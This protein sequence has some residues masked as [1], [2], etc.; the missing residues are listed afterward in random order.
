[1]ENGRSKY[2]I[3]K[4][5]IIEKGWQGNIANSNKYMLNLF[6][7]NRK[8]CKKEYK[9]FKMELANNSQCD[10]A[11]SS[12][13]IQREAVEEAC[14]VYG[15]EPILE[16]VAIN[17]RLIYYRVV[18]TNI[19]LV[20]DDHYHIHLIDYKIGNDIIPYILVKINIMLEQGLNYRDFYRCKTEKMKNI[21][22]TVG[23]FI[24]DKLDKHFKG[25]QMG[26]VIHYIADYKERSADYFVENCSLDHR[27][28]TW[29][30]RM[31]STRIITKEENKNKG[32]NQEY[33]IIDTI[34]KIKFFIG[35]IKEEAHPNK[36]AS[37]DRFKEL[38]VKK[39][40][41]IAA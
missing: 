30:D 22:G 26:F 10:K 34:E 25:K 41:R 15:D 21:L 2:A 12:I 37:P 11:R 32:S 19:C 5:E 6:D 9:N 39:G 18:G 4:E 16:V 29:D 40:T 7:Q 27:S 35:Q 23:I 17:L 31:K 38:R 1:M 24:P 36:E 8:E 20:S 13:Y 14:G 33:L 3:T 28:S